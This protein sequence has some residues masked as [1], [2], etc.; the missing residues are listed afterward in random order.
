MTKRVLIAVSLICFQIVTNPLSAESN[1]INLECENDFKD[2]TSKHSFGGNEVLQTQSFILDQS[3]SESF[4]CANAVAENTKI[5]DYRDY[6]IGLANYF[7][8]GNQESYLKAYPA[9]S[10]F[11]YLCQSISYKSIG[12]VYDCAITS[13]ME[14]IITLELSQDSFKRFGDWDQ[15]AMAEGNLTAGKFSALPIPKVTLLDENNLRSNLIYG[16][17]KLKF[18]T[19]LMIANY[20][21]SY[22]IQ[23]E[24]KNH[25]QNK[26]S[27]RVMGHDL[28][29]SRA[30]DYG[31]ENEK[32]LESALKKAARYRSL[33]FDEL[34]RSSS[35]S[36][37]AMRTLILD[38]SL[39]GILP[40]TKK[41]S[42]FD[43]C[44]QYHKS[45]ID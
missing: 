16:E 34:T 22:H 19:D 21:L 4:F 27:I 13:F 40:E 38:T 23:Q 31:P 11:N 26:A 43:R 44:I 10:S 45:L 42:I 41:R 17:A 30:T 2:F 20:L 12:T 1:S 25:G 5:S 37:C 24:L 15:A 39:I 36:Y 8:F 7:D 35:Q 14:A 6:F 9:L 29:Y 18:Y 32:F 28:G 3:V 33:S